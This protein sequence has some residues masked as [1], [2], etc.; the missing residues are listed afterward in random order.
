MRP[1]RS[2]C[3]TPAIPTSTQ[4]S[5]VT[6][7]HPIS[8]AIQQNIHQNSINLEGTSNQVLD[9]H[10][11][12]YSRLSEVQNH[13]ISVPVCS[14][15]D[16]LVPVQTICHLPR[17]GVIQETPL[18]RD[19]SAAETEAAHDLLELSRSLPPLPHP[20]VAVG[21]QNVI[22]SPPTENVQEIS[23]YQPT[24]SSPIYQLNT[25]DLGGGTA[26]V[27]QQQQPGIIYDTGSATTI[28]QQTSTGVFIPLSPVQEILFTYATAPSGIPSI[29]GA[30]S[31]AIEA[32]PLTPPAS[33]CSSD[34]ENNNP[35]SQPPSLR[36][37]E[38][39]TV[40]EQAEVKAA[41]YTYDTLL[42]ADGRS[43]NKKQSTVITTQSTS[44]ETTDNSEPPEAPKAGRYVCCE[45]GEDCSLFF[46]TFQLQSS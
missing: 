7:H 24:D 23:I 10:Q 31:S 4:V 20:S 32:P 19:R 29:I 43:K 3:I 5:V 38:V 37:K 33:E 42:V 39:Q 27:Y 41:S 9:S 46:V 35:N 44:P 2:S 21:P 6:M 34:I 14:S 28:V 25:I 8:Q 13:Q 36:D 16:V 40:T 30:Q 12:C 1:V 15:L 45:C 18:F 22:E 26:T 17:C 11:L